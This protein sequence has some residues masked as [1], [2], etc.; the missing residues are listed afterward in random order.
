MCLE[1]E[2]L[3]LVVW[4]VVGTRCC[5]YGQK[6]K[7]PNQTNKRKE[8]PLESWKKAGNLPVKETWKGRASGAADS[9]S[10]AYPYESMTYVWLVALL[11]V[12]P[13]GPH[14]KSEEGRGVAGGVRT[15]GAW[16]MSSH[17]C[18]KFNRKAN[19]RPSPVV[20]SS[21]LIVRCRLGWLIWIVMMKM[22]SLQVS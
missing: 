15:R 18:Q 4:L 11:V 1:V 9:L 2:L 21:G 6:I 3:Y 22:V 16:G 8:K 12:S 7:T 17:F 14:R 13:P 20:W 5:A 19:H 10:A